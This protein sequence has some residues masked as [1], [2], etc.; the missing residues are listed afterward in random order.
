MKK[1]RKK[2]WEREESGNEGHG[3]NSVKRAAGGGS[4]WEDNYSIVQQCHTNGS[5]RV[6]LNKFLGDVFFNSTPFSKTSTDMHMC[7]RRGKS[8]IFVHLL[9]VYF[10]SWMVL[11]VCC[12]ISFYCQVRFNAKRLKNFRSY[13]NIFLNTIL[14]R[15]MKGKYKNKLH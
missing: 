3:G 11:L 15:K 2:R 7:S 6:E 13:F 10:F 1:E 8:R 9:L 4:E 5:L 12:N 14:L